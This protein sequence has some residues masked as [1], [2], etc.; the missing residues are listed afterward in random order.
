MEDESSPDLP[1][2]AAERPAAT[3]P[4]DTMLSGNMKGTT[5]VANMSKNV[6]FFGTAT[7]HVYQAEMQFESISDAIHEPDSGISM[8]SGRVA[9]HGH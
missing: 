8:N 7:N 9:S 4:D 6:N 5:L 2:S 3:R 1:R